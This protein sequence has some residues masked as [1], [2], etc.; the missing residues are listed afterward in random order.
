MCASVDVD[1]PATY[2]KAMTSPN[3]NEWIAAMK[4]EL[5]SMAKN[6]FRS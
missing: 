4:E 2:E 6:H 5:S 3:A 1:E